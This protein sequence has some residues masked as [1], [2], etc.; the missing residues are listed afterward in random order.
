[1]PYKDKEKYQ[2]VIQNINNKEI[3]LLIQELIEWGNNEQSNNNI[4]RK[5]TFD[6]NE[7]WIDKLIGLK[8]KI[9][10]GI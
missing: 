2:K 3:L 9:E 7:D 5:S 8:N 1:M 4:Y 6:L 10:D